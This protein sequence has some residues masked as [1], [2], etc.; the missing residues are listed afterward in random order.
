LILQGTTDHLGWNA[1]ISK[2]SGK[3][4]MTEADGATAQ[5]IFGA[6]TPAK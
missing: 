5:M 6:C 3:L 1:T 2:V 4:V